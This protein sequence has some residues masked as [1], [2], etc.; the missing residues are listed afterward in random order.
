MMN[1][2]TRW[3]TRRRVLLVAGAL[4][5]LLVSVIGGWRVLAGRDRRSVLLVTIESLRADHLGCYGS[6]TADTPVLNS[7]AAEGVLFERA[8]V[9]APSCLVS[10]ASIL[11]GVLPSHHGLRGDTP[12]S[13]PPSV[14]PLAEAFHH[15]GY[16][17]AAFVGSSAVDGQFGLARGFDLYD[18]DVGAT[19]KRPG[20]IEYGK[21]ADTVRRALTWLNG[22]GTRPIFAWVY[23]S[24]S[25]RPFS[26]PE[27][28]ASRLKDP[29]DGEIASSDAELGRLIKAFRAARPG[30]LIAVTADHGESL[31]DHGEEAFGY[32]VYGSTTRVPMLVSMPG[33]LRAGR[34]VP[35]VVRTIDLPPTLLEL[36]GIRP[37]RNLD[38]SSLVEVMNG[39]PDGQRRAAVIDNTALTQ[40]YGLAPLVA[41]RTGPYLYVRAPRPELY[42]VDADPEEREDIAARLPQTV[43]AMEQQLA[44][45]VPPTPARSDASDPKDALDLYIR[46]RGAQ[47]IEAE[48]DRQRAAL[49]YRTI[50][51]EAPGFVFARRKLSEVLSREG[52]NAEAELV[53]NE[54]LAKNEATEAT[55]LNLALARY[56]LGH[57]AEAI[58]AVQ[59]GLKALPGSPSLHHR[60]GRLL[61][62]RK[63]YSEAALHLREAVALEPRFLDAHLALAE[64]LRGSGQ[65]PESDAVLRHLIQ[66]APDSVEAR[67]ARAIATWLAESVR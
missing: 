19:G 50:L 39:G 6:K 24:E 29:Y 35:S 32:F 7:I 5:L 65:V 60:I 59:Q 53:L 40:K 43:R 47:Q 3:T 1:R 30:S 20:D 37:P 51:S 55:Y 66:L 26:P 42:D 57:V 52:Q 64:A 67:Q 46:Y 12:A 15:A 14:T 13:L 17:T 21:A 62:E 38:G 31:G 28:W 9:Q 44:A 18:D 27:P 22:Q 10:H 48:G 58:A 61:I 33:K 56:R 4:V 45:V 41:L 34:R 54:L 36:A 8:Y 11:T 23:L 49:I 63:Q 2:S 25:H 16:S